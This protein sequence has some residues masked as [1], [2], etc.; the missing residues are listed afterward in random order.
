[1]NKKIFLLTFF[2]FLCFGANLFAGNSSQVMLSSQGETAAVIETNSGKDITITLESNR[3]T[4]YEWQLA[5]PLK[6]GILAFAHSEYIPS[7]TDLVGAGGKE[8]WTFKALKEG[9]TSLS[10]IYV[11]PWEKDV[12]PAA[13]KTFAVIIKK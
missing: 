7:S 11:R 4:G 6:D 10:F 1:M 12:A 3:T 13:Q 2:L 5:V 9:K 8:K